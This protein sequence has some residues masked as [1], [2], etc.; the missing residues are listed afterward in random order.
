MR[1]RRNVFM[2]SIEKCPVVQEV[3]D[4]DVNLR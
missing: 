1:L 2:F 3:P 4:I